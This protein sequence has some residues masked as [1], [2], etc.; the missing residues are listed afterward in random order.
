[1]SKNERNR[2][3][4]GGVAALVFGL[5]GI[6]SPQ[7]NSNVPTVVLNVSVTQSISITVGVAQVNFNVVPGATANG[8]PTVPVT[9]TWVLDPALTSDVRLYGYF[10][11]ASAAV[12]DGAGSDIPASAFKGRFNGGTYAAFSGTGP[13][14]AAGASLELYSE[15]IRN[16]N[17]ARTRN[18]TLDI[19][20]DLTAFP[21][22]SPGNYTGTLRLQAQAI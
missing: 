21:S 4:L 19:Q 13:F 1:M 14:G 17:R 5:A 8:T 20:I 10:D 7:S 15:S 6:A 22:Q 11:S 12:S 18:D 16:S 3:S 2:I 9:T